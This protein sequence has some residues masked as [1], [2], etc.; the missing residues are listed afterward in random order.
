MPTTRPSGPGAAARWRRRRAAPGRSV[1]MPGPACIGPAGR[2]GGAG[3]LA[4]HH[5]LR[6]S[7][8]DQGR[9]AGE[10][11]PAPH[12]HHRSSLPRVGTPCQTIDYR[13]YRSRAR[14]STGSLPVIAPSHEPAI[15]YMTIL[16][17]AGRTVK[18]LEIPTHSGV[19]SPR[20]DRRGPARGRDAGRVPARRGRDVGAPRGGAGCRGSG[21]THRLA[22]AGPH[23]GRVARR[24]V[25]PLQVHRRH[26]RAVDGRLRVEAPAP[27]R[28][29]RDPSPRTAPPGAGPP[30]GGSADSWYR[31]SRLSFTASWRARSAK[32]R[33]TTRSTSRSRGWASLAA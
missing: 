12:R 30:R 6:G 15:D 9:R 10:P 1:V 7:T 13:E 25:T 20:P 23:A 24:E 4:A 26:R 11:F 3:R 19:E 5:R 2:Q 18:G 31:P 32:S 27:P 16:P 28:A 14:R 17:G 29:A 33:A 22:L 8:R 21:P